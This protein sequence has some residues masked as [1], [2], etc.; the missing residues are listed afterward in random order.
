MRVGRQGTRADVNHSEKNNQRR[1]RLAL[2]V[3]SA[4]MAL[5]GHDLNAATDTWTGTGGNT[6]WSNPANWFAGTVPVSGDDLLFGSTS[7]AGANLN[8]D[9]VGFT[10]KTI[11]FEP[12]APAYTITGN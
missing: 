3:A 9:L 8:N 4:A 2:A 1:Q 6:L 12:F 10:A 7:P 11:E 5:A